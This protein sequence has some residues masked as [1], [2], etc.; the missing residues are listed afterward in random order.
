MLCLRVFT[1]T[2]F[3]LRARVYSRLKIF[4]TAPSTPPTPN[5]CKHLIFKRYF[6]VFWVLGANLP[7]TLSA[8]KVLE[9]VW[10]CLMPCTQNNSKLVLKIRHL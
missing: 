6:Q 4:L 8:I 2:I 7:Y 1:E 10:G 9:R 3:I 5:A